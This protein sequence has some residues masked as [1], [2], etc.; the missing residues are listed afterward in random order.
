MVIKAT[1]KCYGSGWVAAIGAA[2]EAGGLFGVP[3]FV[4]GNKT[5]WGA[6]HLP[7][8]QALPLGP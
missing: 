6:D 5:F 3:A 4:L 8:I 7:D 1:P 2:A